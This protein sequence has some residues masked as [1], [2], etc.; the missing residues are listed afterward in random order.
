M[1]KKKFLVIVSILILIST[2]GITNWSSTA[3]AEEAL[4]P[5]WIKNVFVWYGEDKISEE[6]VINALQ[7]LIKEEILKIPSPDSDDEKIVEREINYDKISLEITGVQELARMP[8]VVQALSV[9]NNEFSAI[10]DVFSVIEQRENDW[11]TTD[12]EVITPFMR[13]LIE[14]DVSDILREHANNYP[15]SMGAEY[16]MYPELI[17]TNSF[18][19]NIAQTGKTTDYLQ[20]DE[21]W[22]IIAKIDGL[23]IS[24]IHYDQSA[25]V[26]SAD[27]GFRVSDD[28]GEFL[29]VIKA[30]TN[31]DQIY[32]P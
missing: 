18:G 27:I 32:K 29:G 17:L 16:E 8:D 13:E 4:I 3:F 28:R 26:Y 10:P 9:S 19:V 5:D 24:E 2:V 15:S 11:T 30:V 14:N 7:W 1:G 12:W 25:D 31:V 23:Y 6:E 20:S 22:W 21:H